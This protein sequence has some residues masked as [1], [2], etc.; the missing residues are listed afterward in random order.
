M[1]TYPAV[2]SFAT[3]TVIAKNL[4]AFRKSVV[5]QESVLS[6]ATF[7]FAVLMS[8]LIYVVNSQEVYI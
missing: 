3:I 5:Y 4:Y 7:S 2:H 8:I 1:W 6:H